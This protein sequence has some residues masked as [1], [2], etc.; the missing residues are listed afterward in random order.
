MDD[1]NKLGTALRDSAPYLTLGIQF[2][3]VIVV[4]F[5]AGLYADEYFDTKPWIMIAAV[6]LGCAGGMIKFLRTANELM[7]R[8]D[9]ERLPKE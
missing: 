8:E 5:V 9:R 4:F 1:D 2:A 7:S 3:A 6:V